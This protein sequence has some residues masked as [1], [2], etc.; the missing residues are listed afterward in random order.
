MLADFAAHE[1]DAKK[2]TTPELVAV[3]PPQEAAALVCLAR[4]VL[5]TDNFITR[6]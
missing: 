3:L 4:A 1:A 2:L 6:E 5:N